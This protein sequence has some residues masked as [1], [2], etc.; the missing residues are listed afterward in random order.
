VRLEIHDVLKEVCDTVLDA[1]VLTREHCL[2]RIIA[3]ERLGMEFE[4]V[5]PD[6][7]PEEFVNVEHKS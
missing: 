1:S 3:L 2:D 7:V 6:I 5:K 4:S